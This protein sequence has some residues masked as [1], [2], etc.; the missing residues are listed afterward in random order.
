MAQAALQVADVIGPHA[1]LFR[2]DA[3]CET[4]LAPPHFDHASETSVGHTPRPSRAFPAKRGSDLAHLA[5][6]QNR[7]ASYSQREQAAPADVEKPAMAAGF[8]MVAR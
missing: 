1:D 7:P 6:V 2:H 5:G 8:S 4:Q 3:L